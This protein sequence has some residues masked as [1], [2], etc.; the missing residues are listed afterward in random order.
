M[1]NKH[2]NYNNFRNFGAKFY[3]LIGGIFKIIYHNL[4]Q[5]F[6]GIIFFFLNYAIKHAK[7]NYYIE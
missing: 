5:L 1:K 7:S 3:H 2:Y 6:C 4:I